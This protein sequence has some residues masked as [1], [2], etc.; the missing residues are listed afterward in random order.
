MPEG[1]AVLAESVGRF[2]SNQ[3]RKRSSRVMGSAVK[4]RRGR[5]PGSDR[6]DL[7]QDSATSTA[8]PEAPEWI[9]YP[10][11]GTAGL[12]N[13]RRPRL[14]ARP[15]RPPRGRTRDTHRAVRAAYR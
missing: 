10:T 11:R 5:A 8:R 3:R 14:P 4:T 13:K 6:R 12:M 1:T 9:A 2:G 15:L 7:R